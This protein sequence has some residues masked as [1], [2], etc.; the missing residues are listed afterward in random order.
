MIAL[1]NGEGRLTVSLRS[2]T[3]NVLPARV[4]A[5]SRALACRP[6]E[7]SS[8]LPGKRYGIRETLS[9]A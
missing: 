7:E 3:S 2:W 5:R 4:K 9:I 8:L 6:P 1:R